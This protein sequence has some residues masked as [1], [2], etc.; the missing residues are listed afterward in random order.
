MAHKSLLLSFAR[1]VARLAVIQVGP[2]L[3]CWPLVKCE[4]II[5]KHTVACS[6][7]QRM[8]SWKYLRVCRM[9][10]VT[11]AHTKPGHGTCT[12]T[13]SETQTE[14][15][16]WR[17]EVRE[18]GNPGESSC[19]KWMQKRMLQHREQDEQKM[20]FSG[21]IVC[22]RSKFV[23]LNSQHRKREGQSTEGQRLSHTS[24]KPT[25]LNFS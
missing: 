7:W 3:V 6:K 10:T 24:I 25:S 14:P 12:G 8:K 22:L 13:E 16:S 19:P 17:V 15:E 1:T 2:I 9:V 21:W 11:L 4:K 20:F 23:K 5:L 18:P